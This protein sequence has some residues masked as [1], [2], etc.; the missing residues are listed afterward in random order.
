[1]TDPLFAAS[2]GKEGSDRPVP[3]LPH[4]HPE[5]AQEAQ[6]L[7]PILNDDLHTHKKNPSPKVTNQF[8]YLQCSVD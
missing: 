1:M 2:G 4:Y 7:E 8:P 6:L 5:A 3:V